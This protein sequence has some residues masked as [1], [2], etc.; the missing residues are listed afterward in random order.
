MQPT[1]KGATRSPISSMFMLA[2]GMP[3]S[4]LPLPK[5]FTTVAFSK[6]GNVALQMDRRQ[7][8]AELF[9]GQPSCSR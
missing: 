1:G 4:L 5:P 3:S 8:S 2:V 6:S 7:G 9:S